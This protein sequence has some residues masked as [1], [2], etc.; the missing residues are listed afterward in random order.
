MRWILVFQRMIAH[1]I[2]CTDIMHTVHIECDYSFTVCMHTVCAYIYI[3]CI[4]LPGRVLGAVDQPALNEDLTRAKSSV[5]GKQR[6]GM[7][8][9]SNFAELI[10]Q[11]LPFFVRSFF[12]QKCQYR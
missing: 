2:A 9:L 1:V 3:C 4:F 7:N 11:S 10:L 12:S 8:Q 5:N 6:I